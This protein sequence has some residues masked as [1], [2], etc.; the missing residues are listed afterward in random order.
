MCWIMMLDYGDLKHILDSNNALRLRV[1]GKRF[2]T[3]AHNMN[4]T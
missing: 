2:Y 4:E 1:P 3:Y